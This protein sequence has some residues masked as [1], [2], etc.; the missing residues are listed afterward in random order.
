MLLVEIELRVLANQREAETAQG[1]G[2]QLGVIGWIFEMHDA[3]I[4]GIAD[5]QRDALGRQGRRRRRKS[6]E[7]QETHDERQP[8]RCSQRALARHDDTLPPKLIWT[9]SKIYTVCRSRQA[10]ADAVLGFR[11]GD[12]INFTARMAEI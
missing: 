11:P 1:L 6:D 9:A 7:R 8:A 3:V 5:H 10:K 4:G 12:A 2:H